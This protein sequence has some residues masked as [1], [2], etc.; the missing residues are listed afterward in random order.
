MDKG[1]SKEKILK[2]IEEYYG[3]KILEIDEQYVTIE[4][5]EYLANKVHRPSLAGKVVFHRKGDEAPPEALYKLYSV[6][7]CERLAQLLNL[8]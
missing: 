8:L 4:I 7:D 2:E 6:K 1:K 5:P 3:L